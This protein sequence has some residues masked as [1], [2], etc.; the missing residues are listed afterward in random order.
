MPK[1]GYFGPRI[2]TSKYFNKFLP[3]LYFQDADFKYDI[4]LR[5]VFAQIP[6]FEHFGKKSI[7]F[8]NLMKIC[9]YTISNVLISN[10]TLAFAKFN[11]NP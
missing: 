9:M 8:L 3:V 10:L 2:S 5:K 7:G 1:F 4:G 11:P 6:K